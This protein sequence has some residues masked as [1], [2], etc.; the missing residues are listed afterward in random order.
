MISALAKGAIMPKCCICH[1]NDDETLVENVGWVCEECFL[2][3]EGKPEDETRK[4]LLKMENENLPKEEHKPPSLSLFITIPLAIVL[5]L[6]AL[7][8]SVSVFLGSG[9]MPPG[10]IFGTVCVIF[11]LIFLVI[12][13]FKGKSLRFNMRWDVLRCL[14]G[15]AVFIVLMILL[16]RGVDKTLFFLVPFLIF[17]SYYVYIT[18]K[19]I[20]TKKSIS[21]GVRAK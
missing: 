1:E 20:I 5:M 16:I 10:S 19:N 9:P 6:F 7:I 2:K 15:I 14:E 11:V 4:I 17:L 8:L 18:I 12:Y 21:K 3:V 13:L